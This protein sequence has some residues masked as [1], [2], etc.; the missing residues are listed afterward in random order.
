MKTLIRSVSAPFRV[1]GRF[2][3]NCWTECPK[4]EKCTLLVMSALLNIG[5]ALVLLQGCASTPQGLAREQ[6]FYAGATNVVGVAQQIAPFLPAPIGTPLGAVLGAVAAALATWNIHQQRTL[7]ALKKQNAAAK[8]AS[9]FQQARTLS[10]L[11]Q[12]ALAKFLA[13]QATANLP[14]PG[15]PVPPAPGVPPGA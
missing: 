7:S 2:V 13:L 1:A 5:L 14:P 9:D 10:A 3:R 12:A 6:R 4:H 15:P 8:V 11:D